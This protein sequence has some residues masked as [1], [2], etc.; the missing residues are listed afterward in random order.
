MYSVLIYLVTLTVKGYNITLLMP[1]A[2]LV[3][4]QQCNSNIGTPAT[5]PAPVLIA[6]PNWTLFSASLCYTA[7]M[8]LLCHPILLQAVHRGLRNSSKFSCSTTISENNGSTE[9]GWP[10]M[11]TLPAFMLT[12]DKLN[13]ENI[14][15]ICPTCT[16]I[17]TKPFL[18]VKGKSMQIQA[19]TQ[20]GHDVFWISW[21]ASSPLGITASR[22]RWATLCWEGLINMAVFSSSLTPPPSATVRYYCETRVMRVWMCLEYSE[23]KLT[24][25]KMGWNS[26]ATHWEISS[27][28]LPVWW[29]WETLLRANL[30]FT[31]R[32][33]FKKGAIFI[34]DNFKVH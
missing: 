16:A 30:C 17:N 29:L 7:E 32:I 26:T 4:F 19:R 23:M 28:G 3:R 18:T 1:A 11:C 5:R 6:E 25:T 34:F 24:S 10:A 13:L 12:M 31:K 27:V 2:Y 8:Q 20:P 21:L 9:Q 15:N 22:N 33:I 14:W